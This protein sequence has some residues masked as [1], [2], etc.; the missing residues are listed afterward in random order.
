MI[1]D[2]D[3]R[4]TSFLRVRFKLLSRGYRSIEASCHLID[5]H[6]EGV[7]CICCILLYDD[8]IRYNVGLRVAPVTSHSRQKT[9][10]S[11]YI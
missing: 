11:R 10:L 6:L 5:N 9:L 7:Y 3:Q 8:Y 1:D 2:V 4:I